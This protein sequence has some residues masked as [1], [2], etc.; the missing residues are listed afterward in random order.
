M[1]EGTAITEV[2]ADLKGIE[3]YVMGIDHVKSVTTAIGESLPRYILMAEV[4][5]K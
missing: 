4:V 3:K 1:P 2:E 5:K